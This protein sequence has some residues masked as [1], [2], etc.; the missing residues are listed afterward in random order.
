MEVIDI[1]DPE[2]QSCIEAQ[3]RQRCSTDAMFPVSP[4]S[5]TVARGLESD[6]VDKILTQFREKQSQPTKSRLDLEHCERRLEPIPQ[7]LK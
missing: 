4:R 2:Q 1:D 7:Q 3:Q 5:H 6:I